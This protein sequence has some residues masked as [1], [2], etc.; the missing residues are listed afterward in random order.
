[1]R[2]AVIVTV[3]PLFD[4]PILISVSDEDSDGVALTVTDQQIH[5]LG[6]VQVIT[7]RKN[8]WA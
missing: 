2:K 3:T 5:H 7:K 4:Y 8:Q 6:L 1:M